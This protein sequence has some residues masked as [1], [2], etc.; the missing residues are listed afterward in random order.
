MI[1]QLGPVELV[2]DLRASPTGG[3]TMRLVRF[4]IGR[5]EFAVPA[6]IRVTGDVA[7]DATTDVSIATP[8]GG[9]R[10]RATRVGER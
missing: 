8:L 6:A 5:S 10:Y 2:F 3:T 1:E 7:S 4:R 9:C